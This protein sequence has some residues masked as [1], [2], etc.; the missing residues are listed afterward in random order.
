MMVVLIFAETIKPISKNFQY[1][2]IMLIISNNPPITA[3]HLPNSS[4]PCFIVLVFPIL[5]HSLFA[6]G[7]IF[8][9]VGGKIQN[10]V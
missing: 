6:S 2:P 3:P 4:P 5:K 10:L 8:I 9:I 1:F 7:I